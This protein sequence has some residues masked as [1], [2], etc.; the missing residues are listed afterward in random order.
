LKSIIISYPMRRLFR[1]LGNAI[2][3]HIVRILDDQCYNLNI[4]YCHSCEQYFIY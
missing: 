1:V 3:L 2:L 4:W